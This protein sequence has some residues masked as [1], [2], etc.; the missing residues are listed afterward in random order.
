MRPITMYHVGFTGQ[1]AFVDPAEVT[2][3]AMLT[4]AWAHGAAHTAD[5]TN[6][7]DAIKVVVPPAGSTPRAVTNYI[8]PSQL[9]T[10]AITTT[11]HAND[12]LMC[13]GG[14]LPIDQ[15]F[16]LNVQTSPPPGSGM[17]GQLLAHQ[18]GAYLPP[19]SFGGP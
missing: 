6:P 9:P 5:S 1:W 4:G 12:T 2:L 8:C 10:P 16:M 19:F 18:D 11:N 15:Q 7:V 13:S 17:G 14:S 3:S